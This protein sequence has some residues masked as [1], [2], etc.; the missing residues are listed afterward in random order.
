LERY[1]PRGLNAPHPSAHAT[2]ANEY[3]WLWLNRDG[4]PTLLTEDV[5]RTIAPKADNAERLKLWAYLLGGLTEHWR[6]SRHYAGVLHFVYLT[7][8]YPGVFTSDHWRDVEKLEL[9][10]DFEQYAGNAFK[11][12]GVY[13]NFWQPKI[14]PGE[15]RFDVSVINDGAEAVQ[16]DL[17]LAIETTEGKQLVRAARTVTV[18]ALGQQTFSFTLDVPDV[19]GEVLVKA[20]ACGAGMEASDAT[21]SR[22]RT[23]LE[24]P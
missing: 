18:G 24:R 23:T 11:P 9:D 10:P 13:L 15:R 17:A 7:C 14:K 20:T 8:S 1:P 19:T 21:V 22:R 16:A 2:I 3:G 12:L 4:T 5:Y 6:A